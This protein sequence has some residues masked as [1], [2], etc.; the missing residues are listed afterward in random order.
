M[1]LAMSA[2]ER[3]QFGMRLI[4][5]RQNND[6]TQT[7]VADEIGCHTSSVSDWENGRTM[8]SIASLRRLCEALGVSADYL[9]DV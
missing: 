1:Q 7:E 4:V 8:P 2:D 6:M 3:L 5:S 9:L